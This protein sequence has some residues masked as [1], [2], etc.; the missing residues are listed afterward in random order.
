MVP[1]LALLA[2]LVVDEILHAKWVQRRMLI[3][4]PV[5]LALLVG[6]GGR[7]VDGWSTLRAI[8]G[9]VNDS[10]T[11]VCLALALERSAVPAGSVVGVYY[12][13][14]TPYFLPHLR[15]H[16]FFGKSDRTIAHGRAH[17]GPP[18]HN[19]WDY[20]YSLGHVRPDLIVT[21][22]GFAQPD[23]ASYR[24]QATGESGFHFGLWLDPTFRD[25][26]R[27]HRLLPVEPTGKWPPQWVY[28]R[29]EW[30]A[31]RWP[32]GVCAKGPW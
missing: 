30:A 9:P 14:T 5:A 20:G 27:A 21:A 22:E 2:G 11:S 18:G 4:L 19:K 32:G 29:H 1:I 25:Q 16:D 24:I 3:M 26:Y 6:L 28:A 10:Y 31:S 15:F 13:G 23:E 17:A 12:A 7:A 8:P